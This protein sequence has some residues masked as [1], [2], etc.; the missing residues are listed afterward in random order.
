MPQDL[1]R[2]SALFSARAKGQGTSVLRTEI[3]KLP[4]ASVD[5]QNALTLFR[6]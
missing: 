6:H 1:E 3:D 4:N 5:E 2:L